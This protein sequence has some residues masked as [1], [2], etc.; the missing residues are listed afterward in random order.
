MA[1]RK[2]TR[3]SGKGKDRG[4]AGRPRASDPYEIGGLVATVLKGGSE[5]LEIGDPLDAEH[6]A[7][8]VLGLF[9]KMPVPFE[10]SQ[11]VERTLLPK[12][13]QGAERMRNRAGL[14]V[15][16][17]LASV[18]RDEE[19]QAAAERMKAHGVAPPPWAAD[20][21]RPDL[22]ET[23]TAA[24]PYGDQVGYYIVFR[25]AGRRQH[26]VL[27]L[28]DEN[29]GG[30]IKDAVAA[31]LAD[32]AVVSEL[33]GR[34]P[35]VEVRAADPA[36]AAQAIVTAVANGDMFIDNDWTRDFRENRALLLSRAWYVLDMQGEARPVSHRTPSAGFETPGLDQQEALIQEFLAS[37][38]GAGLSVDHEVALAVLDHC[39]TARCDFGDGDPLRWSPIAVE[40]FMLDY[41][42]RKA[43]L[44]FAQITAL[45]EVLTAWVSFCLSK[46]G[47]EEHLIRETQEAVA[48]YAPEFRKAVTD[49]DKFGL[50][51]AISNA[52]RADGVDLL[53]AEAV[54]AWMTA[55]NAQP[56]EERD[57]FLGLRL[58]D[59]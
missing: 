5:L 50:A 24:D 8:M 20:I 48:R 1:K 4:T 52:M 9:Y 27:A 28:H 11:E 3:G 12:L 33:M 36:E 2:G 57:A 42:P 47:L 49:P 46:R 45:P 34:D 17:A 37:P 30:I 14:A 43:S 40:L 32:G 25:Y 31:P 39:M 23:W 38:L 59:F 22:L 53:D 55:F 10:V 35:D 15:L 58:Y 41:L 21:G 29:L 44:D 54:D 16:C 7:S 6:W 51:K 26:L 19:A 56:L 13:V 18:T